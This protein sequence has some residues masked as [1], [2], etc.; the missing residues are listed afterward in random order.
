MRKCNGMGAIRRAGLDSLSAAKDH[1]MDAATIGGE[2]ASPIAQQPPVDLVNAATMSGGVDINITQEHPS[3]GDVNAAAMGD[4]EAN[5][6]AQEQPS[7][8]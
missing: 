5:T 7:L 3:M 2:E 6:I 1:L 8:I 4:E